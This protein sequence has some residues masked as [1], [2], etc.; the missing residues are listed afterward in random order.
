VVA[1]SWPP[2][3]SPRPGTRRAPVR[4]R[5]RPGA[6]RRPRSGPGRQPEPRAAPRRSPW[7]WGRPRCA[8]AAA[9]S[10]PP[11][12]RAGRAHC[13]RGRTRCRGSPVVARVPRPGEQAGDRPTL[14]LRPQR[15]GLPVVHHQ[16]G[17]VE[18]PPGDEAIRDAAVVGERGVAQ[19]TARHRDRGALDGVV[20]DLV[21][22]QGLH[23]V[24]AGAFLEDEGENSLVLVEPGHAGGPLEPGSSI[25]GIPSGGGP[26][27]CRG[28]QGPPAEPAAPAR[29]RP[30]VPTARPPG[31]TAP[32]APA[33]QDP[34]RRP[35]LP[36]HRVGRY[37]SGRPRRSKRPAAQPRR[38]QGQS[39]DVGHAHRTLRR[40][41]GLPSGH[42]KHVRPG[43]VPG[44]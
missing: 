39:S 42:G 4:R 18:A 33:R 14:D 21:P 35:S 22:D 8:P 2:A 32:P 24:G 1:I 41:R 9:A 30:R 11:P 28:A 44:T 38:E 7:R 37:A 25:A 23:R 36:P 26:P 13:P 12:R 5:A 40:A 29:P 3:T 10:R 6:R 27:A 17:Q 43:R 34:P 15:L 19:R 31:P 20:D 16:S